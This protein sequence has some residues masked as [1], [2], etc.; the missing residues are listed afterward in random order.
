MGV[1]KFCVFL[2]SELKDNNF[3]GCFSTKKPEVSQLHYQ[4]HNICLNTTPKN[5][6][7]VAIY[8]PYDVN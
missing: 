5:Q 6:N 4:R 7:F 1:Y 2:G 8:T 3:F